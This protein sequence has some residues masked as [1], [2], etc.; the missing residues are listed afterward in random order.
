MAIRIKNLDLNA[1]GMKRVVVQPLGD[2]TAVGNTVKA[3]FITNVDCVIDSVD[4]YTRQG[5]L[6]SASNGSGIGYNVTIQQYGAGS[7]IATRGNTATAINSNVWSA[8]Q[9]LRFTPS[10][11][12][13]L[14]VGNG[15]EA[16][17]NL[18][19]TCVLS[20]VIAVVTY[21]PITHRS[22]R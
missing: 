13:S 12:N 15:I 2:I 9:Q 20:A 8:G 11:A 3:L 5:T 22:T 6:N 21:T 19:G 10:A 4:M 17:F 18:C 7:S 16:V 14:T 1:P